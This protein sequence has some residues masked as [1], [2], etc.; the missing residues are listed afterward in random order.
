MTQPSLPM[1]NLPPGSVV[2][3]RDETLPWRGRHVRVVHLSDD[4]CY[5]ALHDLCEVLM[6]DVGAQ[7]ER[8]NAVPRWAGR[9]RQVALPSARGIQRTM[10]LDVRLIKPWLYTVETRGIRP[11]VAPDLELLK[12]EMDGLLDAVV[13]SARCP[14]LA[15][16]LDAAQPSRV[17][18]AT[19]I[20][21][22]AVVKGASFVVDPNRLDTLE[23]QITA[24][25]REIEANL[26]ALGLE[27]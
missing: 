9:V 1:D 8:V 12:S 10:M 18:S 3:L 21:V 22:H 2:V 4:L 19:E 17:A 7:R 15:L 25:F 20:P 11:D 14:E 27:G 13:F 26:A 6:I 16:I 24:H 5:A 23:A